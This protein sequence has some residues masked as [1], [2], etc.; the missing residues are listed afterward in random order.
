V[1]LSRRLSAA[2]ASK[3][4]Q[5][6]TAQRELERRLRHFEVAC[7][8]PAKPT[9]FA[10]VRPGAEPRR[11]FDAITDLQSELLVQARACDLTRFGTLFLS[12]LSRTRLMPGMPEHIHFDVA[13]RY[14]ARGEGQPGQPE[15]WLPLARHRA[16]DPAI[17]RGELLSCLARGRVAGSGGRT[18][19]A[20]RTGNEGWRGHQSKMGASLVPACDPRW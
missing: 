12:D 19:L 3:L 13:H 15:S 18:W 9:P 14:R 1:T 6:L 10:S 16:R 17:T 5:Y 7:A 20:R 11:Y 8:V 4:D 2:D